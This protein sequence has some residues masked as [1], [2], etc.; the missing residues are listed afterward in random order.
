MNECQEIIELSPLAMAITEGSAHTL[1]S[2]NA[3]FCELLGKTAEDMLGHP[4]MEAI[5]GANGGSILALLD[6][7][8]GG[9]KSGT[10]TPLRLSDPS[11]KH[12]SYLVW[13][14][15][16]VNGPT[17]SLVIQVT[18]LTEQNLT[19]EHVEQAAKE[20]VALNREMREI[21]EQLVLSGLH[22]QTLAD[23]N[24]AIAEALQYSI[25]WQQPE[26]L[27]QGLKVA[28][29]YEPALD[30][31]LVG[32]DFFDAFR[33]PNKSLM[34][35]VGDVTGKGLK[36]AARTVEI[37][38]ALRAFAQ[39]YK[40]PADL[41]TRLNEFICD[42]HPEDDGLGNDFVVLSLIIVDHRRDTSGLGRRRT[43]ARPPRLRRT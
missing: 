41:I 31:A 4:V 16:V 9:E 38:F 8:Y 35:V 42:F 32:G 43:A 13:G 34:L 28:V 36:A 5:S 3:A 15:P 30:D 11:H 2:V 39:D 33:L 27:F 1:M 37:T 12:K 29:F 17:E 25:L 6:R 26:K 7:I 40:N 10:V 24:R 14:L 18:D 21:N 19:N 23:R 20:I 22:Q